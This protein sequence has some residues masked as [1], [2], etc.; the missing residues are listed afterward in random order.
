MQVSGTPGYQA[1]VEDAADSILATG[2]LD[3]GGT[4]TMTLE[5]APGDHEIEVILF[6]SVGSPTSLGTRTVTVDGPPPP[7][8]SSRSLA[9]SPRTVGPSS[10]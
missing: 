9:P 1:R 6:D 4:T 10:I 7:R 3:D 8:P 2:L 5:R